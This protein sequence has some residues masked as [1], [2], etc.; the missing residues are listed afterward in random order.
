MTR[1]NVDLP[2]PFNLSGIP[3]WVFILAGALLTLCCCCGPMLA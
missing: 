2:G 3:V 1:V